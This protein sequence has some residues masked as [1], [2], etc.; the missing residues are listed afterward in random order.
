MSSTSAWTRSRQA[1]GRRACCA[2]TTGGSSPGRWRSPPTTTAWRASPEPRKLGTRDI[3]SI[4]R[5]YRS[6]TFGFASRNFYAEFLAAWQIEQEPELYFGVLQPD[7]PVEYTIVETD[8]FY[9]VPS[10]ER[11]LGVDRELLRD[12]NLALRPAVW[13]G[14][15][16]VPRGYPLRVPADALEVPVEL[17]LAQIPEDERIAKQHRDRFP[18]GAPR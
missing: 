18:Q 6:R 2:T 13:N 4:A 9:A 10:L 12:H 16:L 7:A 11:A 5:R 1:S 8:H 14:A 15:K 17:A 3:G